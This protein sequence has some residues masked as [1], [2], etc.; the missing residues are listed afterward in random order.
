MDQH[1]IAV[2]LDRSRAARAALA[3]AVRT[4][5]RDHATV[6][7]VTA[8]PDSDRAVARAT[9]ALPGGRIRLHQLQRDA[10]AEA[11]VGVD[12]APLVVREI[13]YAAPDVALCHASIGA[14]LLVIGSDRAGPA[15]LTTALKRKLAQQRALRGAAARLVVV[16]APET[17]MTTAPGRAALSAAA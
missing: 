1:R 3:W 14:D 16:R 13:L 2:G 17:S 11:L 4:A 5:G 9:G 12:P 8:W 6:L 15:P 10:I 7:V